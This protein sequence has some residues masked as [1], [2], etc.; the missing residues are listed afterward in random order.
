MSAHNNGPHDLGGRGGEGPACAAI[1]MAP[2]PLQHWEYS[3]HALLILL[4]TKS[5]PMLSTDELRR[6]VEGLEEPAYKSWGYYEKWGASMSKILL[7]R[8]V[9]SEAELNLEL[10]GSD[11]HATAATTAPY[12]EGTVVRVCAED[13]RSRWRK[14]HLR[15]PGYIF[16]RVGRIK[17]YVGDFE[18]PYFLAFRG[19]GP[20]QHLYSVEFNMSDIWVGLAGADT[21]RARDT[22]A[23]DIYHTWLTAEAEAAGP[24]MHESSHSDHTHTDDSSG[25]LNAPKEA[26]GAL[27]KRQKLDHDHG[28][29]HEER[30]AV[31]ET[32]LEREGAP[33][34]G[35]EVGEALLRLMYKKNIVTEVAVTKTIQNIDAAGKTMAGADLVA[36]SWADPAFKARLLSNA[37]DA[38]LEL[39]IVTSNPNAPTV[40]RVVENSPAVHNVVVCTLCSCYPTGLLGLSPPW[41]KSRSYRSRV[42]KEPRAVLREFGTVVPTDVTIRVH[43]STADC[44]YLV[45]PQRPSG[46]EGWS[47]E[48]LKAIVTRDGMVGVAVL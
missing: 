12:A 17:K 10:F 22:V 31:E 40:L 38:A 42:V 29:V 39:G 44:R 18:D 23:L 14:P 32:A 33:S 34:P 15:C 2:Q 26:A 41:Y 37:P 36:K 6:G 45:I 1:D 4:S 35:Q 46:T 24:M 8:G 7:E 20:R 5:P 19:S 21:V 27:H 30:A 48:Q 9:I 11:A 47:H 43:D 3:I 13:T 25:P 16:G 28:H